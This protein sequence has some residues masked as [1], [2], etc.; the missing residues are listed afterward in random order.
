MTTLISWSNS[1][2][3]QGRCDAKCYEAT[4][5]D[6]DC[7]C[8]GR[9]HGAGKTKAIEN[10]RSLAERMI[11]EFATTREQAENLQ[12]SINQDIY[13]LQMPGF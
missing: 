6:C 13:Q 9:N 11:D 1:N 5:P 7:I 2:G 10:T 3:N 8:G 4:S 12:A